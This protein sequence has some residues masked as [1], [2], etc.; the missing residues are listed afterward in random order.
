MIDGISRR[1]RASSKYEGTTSTT[2]L[3]PAGDALLPQRDIL[4]P[5]P[6]DSGNSAFLGNTLYIKNTDDSVR[7]SEYDFCNLSMST[8]GVN[9]DRHNA[10]RAAPPDRCDSEMSEND[11]EWLLRARHHTSLAL[12]ERKLRKRRMAKAA[13][14]FNERAK[15]K[16]W[17][18]EAERLGMLPEPATPAS[19]A[20]FLYST[21]GLDRA[22]I[23]LYISKGPKEKYRF[24][25]EVLERFAALFDFSGM[26]FSGALRSFLGRFRLP[27]EAQCIDR[28]MEAF[29]GRLYEVQ[30]L[31][32]P[33]YGN[34]DQ[35]AEETTLEQPRRGDSDGES[36]GHTGLLDPPAASDEVIDPVFPFK[37]SDG[38]FILSFSTI[39]LNTDL[40][41]FA[42]HV[43]IF[44]Y[45]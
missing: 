38:A 24:H 1:C 20:S 9:L 22:K 26:S 13:A 12:R 5:S 4:L 3:P 29:A 32:I 44:F 41:K 14:E 36:G 42:P 43:M 33:D 25:A 7:S 2:L 30:L 15:D 31:T 34:G 11:A 28:L 10:T 37:S 35:A 18:E 16:E 27:G 39:M 23:G 40:R 19:V 6:P 17:I 21:P 45:W 8:A